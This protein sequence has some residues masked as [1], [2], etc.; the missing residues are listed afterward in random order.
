MKGGFCMD[1]ILYQYHFDWFGSLVLLIP[2]LVGLGFFFFF[3]WYP[4]QNP[5]VNQKGAKGHREYVLFKWIGWIVGSL[6]LFLFVVFH[7]I[8]LYY[9]F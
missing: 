5:G 4:V 6:V 8:F 3:K 2:L 7:L 9:S 1:N